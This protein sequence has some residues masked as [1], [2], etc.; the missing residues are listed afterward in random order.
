[1]K[2]SWPHISSHSLFPCLSF[3]VP[4]LDMPLPL[5]TAILTH[6]SRPHVS[7]TSS[8]AALNPSFTYSHSITCLACTSLHLCTPYVSLKLFQLRIQ[9]SLDKQKPPPKQGQGCLQCHCAEGQPALKP[10]LLDGVGGW[11]S[12]VT[13]DIRKETLVPDP[14]TLSSS[15]SPS[16]WQLQSLPGCPHPD[17]IGRSP[18]CCCA[19]VAGT[20]PL[21]HSG[22][23][24]SESKVSRGRRSSSLSSSRVPTP[25]QPNDSGQTATGE[26][27]ILPP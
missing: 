11:G 17:Q 24:P 15:L 7:P 9:T 5:F 26:R 13:G 6:L 19:S 21:C 10:L 2:P 12:S 22:L 1:M 16:P 14:K 20:Q 18:S 3:A 4:P 27:Q 23:R 25:L 8:P